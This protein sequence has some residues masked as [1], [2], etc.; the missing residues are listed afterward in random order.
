MN[1]YF[2]RLINNN[3]EID[4]SMCSERIRNIYLH[5]KYKNE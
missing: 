1:D 5:I 2:E 3:I 4:V